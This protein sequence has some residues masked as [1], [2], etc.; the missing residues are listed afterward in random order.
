MDPA[1]FIVGFQKCGTTSLYDTIMAHPD[2]VPGVMKENNILAEKAERLNEF[3]LCFPIKQKGKITGDASHLHTWMPY[4]LERIKEHYPSAKI[5]VIMRDP[6]A[7]AFS[8][9]NMDHKIGYLPE[10]LSFDQIINLE[11]TLRENILSGSVD[12]V[13]QN[14][15]LYGNRYGWPLS[16]GIYSTYI[17]KIQALNLEFLPLFMEDLSTDHDGVC[18]TVFSFLQLDQITIP[19]KVKNKGVYQSSLN[20][21]TEDRLRTFYEPHNKRLEQLLDKPLPWK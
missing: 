8:H 19:A 5:I 12:D 14:L 6:V 13:Y 9:F 4:G 7:R 2:V 21:E 15:K 10:K 1:F 20:K 11:M 18:Q 3:K 17:E 16:R